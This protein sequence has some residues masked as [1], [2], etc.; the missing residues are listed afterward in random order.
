MKRTN[1]I[2]EEVSHVDTLG[3]VLR[4]EGSA[5]VHRF[6]QQSE[7]PLLQESTSPPTASARASTEAHLSCD[8]LRVL[9]ELIA[10]DIVKNHVKKDNTGQHDDEHE[11]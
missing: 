4:K 8:S 1:P 10:R 3:R 2:P 9:A 5:S 6:I 7:S 11:Y